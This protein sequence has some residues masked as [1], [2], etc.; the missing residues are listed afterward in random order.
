M[1]IDYLI[2]GQGLSGTFLS[3]YLLQA[4][5]KVFVI[6]K[7]TPF[8]ASKVAS[9]VINPV[10][11]RR[12]VRTWRIEEL[13]PFALKAYT[14]LGNEFGKNLVKKS[15]V[16]D[17]H[18]SLQMKEAFD[19]RLSEEREYLHIP[20]TFEWKS[21]FN[22]HF[23]IGE[24]NPCLLADI[25]VM[26]DCWREKLTSEKVLINEEF[27][28][29]NCLVNND[30]IT[31]KNITAKKIIFCDGVAGTDNPFFK[32]LPYAPNK[33]EAIIAKIPGLPQNYIYK[34][35]ISIVPWRDDLFWIGS[36]YEWNFANVQ[37]T[38]AYRERVA[39]QLKYWL[40][41]PFEIVDHIA[42]V[43]PANMERRPFVGLHPR[44]STVGILNG[45]GTKG[46]SLAPFF[47][48]QL[49]S[50]LTEGKPI[51]AD[52]DVKRFEKILSRKLN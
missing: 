12:I 18:P 52:A 43:R 44:F 1:S 23:D 37:P 45:M 4:G 3:Y 38:S 47:A 17:F 48:K 51:Y 6:D 35:G 22:Y 28:W 5:K 26:L 25:N 19:K 49:T 31:Y 13:L 7:S 8:T 9:G 32:N 50:H 24:I 10:T 21:Y 2:I 41:V 36:S 11:G 15:S 42:S 46:C 20:A 16:L 27:S 34:Q 39:S 14:E 40:K 29:D 30:F 33:G